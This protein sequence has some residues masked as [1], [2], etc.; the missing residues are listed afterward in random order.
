[1]HEAYIEKVKSEIERLLREGKEYWYDFDV[2]RTQMLLIM[3][4]LSETYNIDVKPCRSCIGD[5]KYD[6]TIEIR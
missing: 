5:K 4:N 6:V 2:S 1:M 3:N